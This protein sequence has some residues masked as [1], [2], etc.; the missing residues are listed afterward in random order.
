MS[1]RRQDFST[2]HLNASVDESLRRLRS[3]Y[4]DLFQLHSPPGADFDLYV[5]CGTCGGSLA[6]SSIVGGQTGHFDTVNVRRDDGPFSDDSFDI[7]I[8]VRHFQSSF[9]AVRLTS[10]ITARP[11]CPALSVSPYPS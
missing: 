10:S 9:C 6:G 11:P 7:T 1:K 2:P 5:Y 3:D 4:V 8:E